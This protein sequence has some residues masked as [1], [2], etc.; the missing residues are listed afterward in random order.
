MRVLFIPHSV[1]ARFTDCRPEFIRRLAA[2]ADGSNAPPMISSS[3]RLLALL[4]LAHAL[5]FPRPAEADDAPP[6]DEIDRISQTLDGMKASMEAIRSDIQNIT[7]GVQDSRRYLQTL[8]V[9]PATLVGRDLQSAASQAQSLTFEQWSAALSANK[10]AIT[11]A[12]L[13]DSTIRQNIGRISLQEKEVEAEIGRI[14]A[15]VAEIGQQFATVGQEG[16]AIKKTFGT[17]LKLGGLFIK[18]KS[19]AS[20]L[21]GVDQLVANAGTESGQFIQQVGT[22]FALVPA[23]TPSPELLAS[24]S[25]ARPAPTTTTAALPPAPAEPAALAAPPAAPAAPAGRGILAGLWA[26]DIT[27]LASGSTVKIE[28][29]VGTPRPGRIA[30][31]LLIPVR[32]EQSPLFLTEA[33][34]GRFVFVEDSAAS[35]ASR[36]V[37]LSGTDASLTALALEIQAADGTGE[38]SGQ[39][40]RR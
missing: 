14:K 6:P 29:C 4:C 28:L 32:D 7:S 3:R 39:L 22:L 26:G 36:H 33:R 15:R 37:I 17:A 23:A 21:K 2:R 18:V 13:G 40:A 38:F 24:L 5:A 19:V 31:Y 9:S 27:H 30:G 20:E 11:Q 8:A 34:D 10:D 25:A 35:P 16:K 12:L 1:F